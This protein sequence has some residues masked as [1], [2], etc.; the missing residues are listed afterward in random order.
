MTK[1]TENAV[2]KNVQ[3]FKTYK[4]TRKQGTV[5]TYAG[6]SQDR[7]NAIRA[8]VDNSQYAKVDGTMIDLFS[9]SIIVKIYDNLNEQNQ[10]KFASFPAGKMGEIAYKLIS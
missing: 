3:C 8:I 7:I 2:R 9:A 4:K 1:A 5:E 10:A 6:D